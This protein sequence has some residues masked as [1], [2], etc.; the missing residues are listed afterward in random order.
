MD[1]KLYD[2]PLKVELSRTE[3]IVNGQ[4]HPKS[5]RT[6]REI[7]NTL[8]KKPQGGLEQTLYYMYRDVYKKSDIRFDITVIPPNH[9]SK[10]YA[11][12]HGHYHPKGDDGLA[13]PELYQI[14]KGKCTFILQK[15]NKSDRV[16]VLIITANEG[17][18]ILLPPGYGHVSINSSTSELVMSNLVYD[19]FQASYD[20]YKKNHGAAFYYLLGGELVQNSNYVIEKSEQLTASELNK[21]YNYQCKDLLSEFYID[22]KKFEFLVKPNLFFK[23]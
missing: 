16:E 13:Y 3:L 7:V 14:L 15:K 12:T 21:R 10:E 4:K 9:I 18:V 23:K 22:P 20:E 17:D 2:K 19:R 1:T 8:M 6:I 5:E 11:K